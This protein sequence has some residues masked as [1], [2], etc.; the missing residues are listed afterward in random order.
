M[1]DE[2][3]NLS[4]LLNVTTA[5]TNLGL[6]SFATA[7]TLDL[8]S[9]SATGILAAA[10]M[11]AFAGDVTTSAGS[12]TTTVAKLRGVTI[13]ATAP[14]SGQVLTYDGTQWEPGTI[15]SS[16][17]TTS[18]A[19]V[20]FMNKVGIGVSDPDNSLT[21]SQ[22]AIGDSQISLRSAA[23]A[24]TTGQVIGGIEFVTKDTN[25]PAASGS[26]VAAGIQAVAEGTHTL[27]TL[28]TGLS[29]NTMT[30]T[31][32]SEALRITNNNRLGLGGVTAPTMNFSVS[33][34]TAVT[35]GVERTT[36]SQGAGSN[37]TMRAG[38]A[39]AGASNK[40]GGDLY[41]LAGT[42]TGSGTSNIYFQTASGTTVGTAD[43]AP[44]TRMII[45]GD[46][47][48]GFGTVTPTA[49][50]ELAAGA[51][52]KAPLRFNTG[53]LLT[54]PLTGTIEYNGTDFYLTNGASIRKVIATESA[55]GTLE[56]ISTVSGTGNISLWPGATSSIIVSA[57]TASTN[58]NTGA[59][60][61]KG[62]AGISGAVN[63]AGLL[64][65]TGAITTT[66][67]MTGVSVTATSGMITPWLY[68]STAASGD[69]RIE[70]TTSATKGDVLIAPNGGNVGIGTTTPLVKLEVSG[71]IKISGAMNLPKNS[72][73]PA[74][75]NAASDG[76]LVLTSVY[77]TC[78]CKNGAGWVST[79]DGTTSCNWAG[80][81]S[82]PGELCG[83]GAI[84]LG[85]IGADDYMTTP[86]GCSD[87]PAGLV[88]GGSGSSSYANSNFTPAF[89]SGTDALVKTWNDG[90]SNYYDIPGLTNYFSTPNDDV[91]Y[92]SANTTN[93]VA[94]TAG[95][96]GGYHAAARYCD[97]LSLNGYN[98]WHLPNAAELN[99]MY[100]NKASIPGLFQD[101]NVYYWSST[102]YNNNQVWIQEFSNGGQNGFNNK[103]N[104]YRVR[105]VRRF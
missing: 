36:I 30:G 66:S 23:A 84:F 82:S 6:G 41:L 80:S 32:L 67:N 31:T 74:T 87:I 102:E 58:S 37:L 44:T 14:T 97:K 99:L 78:V 105:C 12:L 65:A 76:N 95:A 43:A 56:G 16:Q 2:A 50:L 73:A 18:G 15:S 21:V 11:P 7:S 77:T 100:T 92:G 62:G 88:A 17:W 40:N 85:T 29:F 47:D 25:I 27:T 79:V 51:A 54:T 3:N 33:G 101:S 5:R 64:N 9:V 93:I 1:L 61:V 26:V 83:G 48:I 24:I 71:S 46:G 55:P 20:Y 94:I 28:A 39:N 4:D 53:T 103:S 45:T 91:N 68:G 59:L 90:T 35:M 104:S 8:G 60:V 10:R 22:T 75:C 98:D 42:A 86:G 72:S 69:L 38:G 70:S 52:T 81:C 13:A 34:S 49:K 89:C 63:I 57:T 96:Q 19:N